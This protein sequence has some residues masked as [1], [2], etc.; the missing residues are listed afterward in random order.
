MKLKHIK[1]KEGKIKK[2]NWVKYWPSPILPRILSASIIRKKCE[3]SNTS[4]QVTNTSIT[5]G[6]EECKIKEQHKQK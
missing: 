6:Y 2:K 1:I 3:R 5:H 4:K